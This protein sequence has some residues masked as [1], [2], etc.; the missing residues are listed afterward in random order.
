M[1]SKKWIGIGVDGMV[2]I[3]QWSPKSTFGANKILM[4]F[5]RPGIKSD[6]LFLSHFDKWLK[7]GP[8]ATLPLI[9]G[10]VWSWSIVW[11]TSSSSSLQNFLWSNH[12]KNACCIYVIL[13]RHPIIGTPCTTSE[14]PSTRNE[15]LDHLYTEIYMPY[16]SAEDP[17]K[18]PNGLNGIPLD[19]IGPPVPALP[20][21]LHEKSQL[22][23]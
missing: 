19:P 7:L 9:I 4:G 23:Y 16:E 15:N 3:G 13:V 6:M 18:Q 8:P 21:D 11:Q 12:L 14:A 22:I 20:N 1:K 17:S 2:I 10:N 5:Q